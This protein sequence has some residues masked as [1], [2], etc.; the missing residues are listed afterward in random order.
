MKIPLAETKKFC[1]C[2]KYPEEFSILSQGKMKPTGV[3]A[4]TPY[5]EMRNS[6]DEMILT[7]DEII[8]PLGG[9]AVLL[10]E[11]VPIE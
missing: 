10:C 9:I 6:P 2:F 8:F 1:D 5:W 7:G 11:I 3:G 4:I